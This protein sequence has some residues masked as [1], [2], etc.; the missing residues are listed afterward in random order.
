MP[1]GVCINSLGV[2]EACNIFK[3]SNIF[4]LYEYFCGTSCQFPDFKSTGFF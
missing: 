1:F 2:R 3:Y 4:V